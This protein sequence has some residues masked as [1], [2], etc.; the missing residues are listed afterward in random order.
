[1][2]AACLVKHHLWFCTWTRMKVTAL[3]RPEHAT[4]YCH[5]VEQSGHFAPWVAG[6]E[7]SVLQLMQSS[8]TDLLR[9]LRPDN[10]AAFAELFVAAVLQVRGMQ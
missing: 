3:F 9:R 2:Q 1:M 6:D 10:F 4:P 5:Y 8:A 7:S